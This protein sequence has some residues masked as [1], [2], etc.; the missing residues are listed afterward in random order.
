MA[1]EIPATIIVLVPWTYLGRQLGMQKCRQ[2]RI[3]FGMVDDKDIDSVMSLMPRNA[4]YYFTKAS[5]HRAINER[6]VCRHGEA[7]GLEGT[8]HA[9]VKSAY[10]AAM[11]DADTGDFIFV[12]GS[13]YVVADFLTYCV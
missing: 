1:T 13:S 11:A 4:V 3:V 6:E 5:T 12:G 9:D 8:C 2:M 10:M 7:H